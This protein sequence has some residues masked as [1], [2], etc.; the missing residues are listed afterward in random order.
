MTFRDG[1]ANAKD[2][3]GIYPKG[4]TPGSTG[5]TRWSYVNGTQTATS[6]V[7]SGSVTFAAGLSSSG[8]YDVHLLRD[9]GYAILAS[10]VFSVGVVSPPLATVKALTS[11]SWEVPYFVNNH[12]PRFNGTA[13]LSGDGKKLVLVRQHALGFG[14]ALTTWLGGFENALTESDVAQV[15]LYGLETKDLKPILTG[16]HAQ[17]K[18]QNGRSL[19]TQMDCAVTADVNYDGSRVLVLRTDQQMSYSADGVATSLLNHTVVQLIET[20][21]GRVIFEKRMASGGISQSGYGVKLNQEGTRAVFLH[22]PRGEPGRTFGVD[23]FGA[24]P[25]QIFSLALSGNTEPTKLSEGDGTNAP[26][27]YAESLTSAFYSFDIDGAGSRVVFAYSD[28]KQVVGVNFD[29]TGRHVISTKT[30]V[31]YVSLTRDGEHAVYSFWGNGNTQDD[32][33]TWVNT[34]AGS[35]ER[36]LIQREVDR[37]N[38]DQTSLFIPGADAKELIYAW[39]AEGGLYRPSETEPAININWWRGRLVDASDDLKTVL[40]ESVPVGGSQFAPPRTYYISRFE[41]DSDKDGLGDDWERLHFGGLAEGAQGDN[42]ADGFRNDAEYQ[43]GTSPKN[44]DSD[45]DGIDDATEFNRTGTDPLDARSRLAVENVSVADGNVRFRWNTVNGKSYRLQATS[46][47]GAA[48]GWQNLSESI[49]GEGKVAEFNIPLPS[50]STA[51][52]YRLVLE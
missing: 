25:V 3:I 23:Y 42:D 22:E 8:T 40:T 17:R 1:P 28:P 52:F 32:D 43:L 49:R 41:E 37:F 33:A 31:P 24:A 16:G 10:A 45:G 18:A 47:L 26:K 46:I 15:Y 13:R 20:Q 6:G 7:A 4:V 38:F 27:L 48:D 39:R 5:S 12:D 19:L 9:D 44:K 29:G 2:W 51:I 36:A 35:A 21:T 50:Q 30:D 11:R 34:F 14:I